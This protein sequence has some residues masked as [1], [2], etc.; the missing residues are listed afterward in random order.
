[1]CIG[2]VYWKGGGCMCIGREGSVCVLEGRGCMC[3]GG[4]CVLEGGKSGGE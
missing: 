2:G 1:M 4:V 3:I